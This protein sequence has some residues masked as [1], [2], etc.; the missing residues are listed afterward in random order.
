MNNTNKN[1]DINEVFE[2]ARN[3]AKRYYET[4]PPQLSHLPAKI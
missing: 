2:E 3:K 4:I 1:K